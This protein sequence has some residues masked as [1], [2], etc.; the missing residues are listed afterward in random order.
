M[1]CTL[2]KIPISGRASLNDFSASPHAAIHN[3]PKM[4]L[5]G[6]CEGESVKI[7]PHLAWVEMI[8]NNQFCT[9]LGDGQ[10]SCYFIVHELC[11]TSIF[12]QCCSVS[13]LPVIPYDLFTCSSRDSQR[14]LFFTGRKTDMC[15]YLSIK[16]SVIFKRIN[17]CHF[18][19]PIGFD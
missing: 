6:M 14:R 17:Y 15:L 10:H 13:V 2:L 8:S 7:T 18:K 4:V 1:A 5:L 11:P 12:T 3:A 16:S 19:I 9:V